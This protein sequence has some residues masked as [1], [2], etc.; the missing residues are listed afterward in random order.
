MHKNTCVSPIEVAQYVTPEVDRIFGI[1]IFT[2]RFI[3]SWTPSFHIFFS[4]CLSL[5]Y[6]WCGDSHLT[7]Q[8]LR[9]LIV[10]DARHHRLRE[11]GLGD[12]LGDAAE[13]GGCCREHGQI[14]LRLV[15]VHRYGADAHL[16]GP[17][18]MHLVLT[19]AAEEVCR[20][21][22]L[23]IVAGQRAQRGGLLIVRG[24]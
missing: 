16:V 23:K 21:H 11:R 19:A 20:Y 15:N 1:V 10:G 17:C 13:F 12:R 3:N 8:G 2:L 6:A 24:S 9:Q 5:V 7:D 18:H 22:R 14:R 4:V